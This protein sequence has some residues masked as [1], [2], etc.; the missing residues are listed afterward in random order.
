M[1]GSPIRQE[2]L[3]TAIDWLSESQIGKYMSDHQH[4]ADAVFLDVREPWDYLPQVHAALKGGGFFG[5][6][7]PTTN[8]VTELLEGLAHNAFGF[9]QVDELLLRSYKAVAARL[10]PMDR[11]VAHTGYLIFARALL[12]EEPE[13]P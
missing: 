2:F 11:M 5:A 12:L 9:V 1:N 3:E 13:A 7:V 4:D 8:Q 10:R 6:L